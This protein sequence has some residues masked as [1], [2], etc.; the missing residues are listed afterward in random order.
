M[1]AIRADVAY[2][3]RMRPV[4][5]ISQSIDCSPAE[6]YAFA[7]DPHNL[8]KW[9]H[10]LGTEVQVHDNVV[11]A[12]G[13]LGHIKIVFAPRN[14]LGVLD[15]DVTLPNG[16]TVHNPMRVMP[17]AQGSELVFSVFR[18]ASATDEAFEKDCA[19]V[20]QDLR[21]LAQLIARAS[22]CSE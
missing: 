12:N 14:Q 19:A 17:N 5:H 20:A 18:D 4:K 10:G 13:P 6:A 7:A 2:S 8:S 21:K 3:A 15:H 22:S 16:Q 1:L 9:A 11:T